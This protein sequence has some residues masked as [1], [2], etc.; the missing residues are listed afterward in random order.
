[1]QQAQLLIPPGP[2]GVVGR[3]RLFGENIEAGEPTEGLVTVEVVD[4]TTAL[5]VEQFQRQQRSQGAQGGDH[6]RAGIRGPGDEAVETETGQ[7]GHEEEDARD[8]RVEGAARGE[9]QPPGVRDFGRIGGRPVP[10][11]RRP[12]RSPAPIREE[13]E[14]VAPQRRSARK[15][16]VIDRSAE[17]L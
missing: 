11:G 10:A 4:V 6:L 8:A 1:L 16:L 3:E 9:V 12:A 13:K 17:T 14:G 2:V 15:R 5:L 7:Q